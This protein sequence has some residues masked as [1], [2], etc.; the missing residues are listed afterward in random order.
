MTCLFL[1]TSRSVCC[2]PDM[3]PFLVSITIYRLV[4]KTKTQT[5]RIK[6]PGIIKKG[7]LNDDSMTITRPNKV[8]S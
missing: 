8:V 3:D 6:F 5:M 7:Y 1:F 2:S 4:V